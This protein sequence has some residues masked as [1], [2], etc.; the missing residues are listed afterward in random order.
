M[1]P[2]RNWSI[3]RPSNE[4]SA[5]K[6]RFDAHFIANC[7]WFRVTGFVLTPESKPLTQNCAEAR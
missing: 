1:S 5:P 7:F 2:R 4:T 3:A 6:W